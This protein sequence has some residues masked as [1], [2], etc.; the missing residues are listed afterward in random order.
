MGDG[1]TSA[2]NA[3]ASLGATIVNT[4]TWFVEL[5]HVHSS[6]LLL[7]MLAGLALAAGF[8]YLIG[9]IGWA[10]R[11]LGFVV[12]GGIRAGFRLWERLLAWASWPLF[13]AIVLGFLVGGGVVGGALPSVRVVCGLAPLLM[14]AIACLAYMF[15]DLERYE[16]E[17][18]HMAVHNPLKGQVLAIHLARYGQQVRAPLLIAATVAMIGGFALLNQGLYVTIGRGWYHVADE[19]REPI[20]VD[21][22]AYAITKLLGLVDVLD[23]AESHRLLR[24][25]NVRQAAWPASI[26]LAGFKAFFSLVLLQQIFASL[27]QGKLLAETITD[28]WSPHEPIHDRARNALAQYGVR[29]I[30]PLLVSLRSVPSLTKEQRDQLPLILA[31]IGPSTIPALVRHLHDPHEHVR[32]IAAAALGQ[33]HALDTVPLLAALGQDPSAV[34]RQ[35]VVEALGI[36]GGAATEL[37]PKKRRLGRGHGLRGRRIGWLFRWR[38]RGA[39]APLLNLVELAVATLEPA[40][41][42]DSAAVRTQAALALGRIGPPAAAVAPGLID[43]LEDADETVRCQAAEALGQVGGDE[44][45]TVAALVQLLQDASAPVKESAARAL[46]ALRKAAAP[47]VAALVPLLQDREESVR[48]AA[49]E[50]IA[51]VGPLNEAATDTLVEGL[52]SPDNVVRAQTAEALGTI[53]A[54]AEEAAPALVE[55]MADGNDRVRAKAVEALGKIGESAAAAAVPGLVRALRDQDNWVSALAAEAL[56]QMGES[57]DATV[58]ALVRSLGHL[59]PRVRG[60]SAEALGKMGEAAVAARSALET[61]AGD[62]D[63]GVR[64][65]A[66]RAL[67]TIGCPTPTSTQAIM[68]GL[69]DDD[70]LARAA[71]VESLGH[72]AEPSVAVLIGL[73]PLLEDANDQVKV[74][75]TKVLPRLA[76]ASPAVVDGLC[77]RLVEDDSAWVQVH[78]ALALGRLGRAAAAAGGPLLRAAQTGDVSVREQAMRAIALIQPPETAEAFAAGLKDACSDIRVVAS[79]GWMKAAAIP[80]EAIPTLVEALRDPETQVRANAAHALGRLD[81]LPAAAVTLL[82]ECA[83]DPYDGLRMNAA[84]ALKLA[85]A[86]AVVEVMQHLLTDPNPRV[87][88]I[89]A[90]TL[91]SAEPDNAQACAVVVEA[92]G[93]PVLRVRTASLKLV[94]SLGPGGSGFLDALKDREGMEGEAELRDVVTCLIERLENQAGLEL[95]AVADQGRMSP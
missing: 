47:A 91:L 61:A 54:A 21:F 28:F 26:L 75:V 52:D 17:R 18:G 33:L 87:R 70:P 2:P 51:Q 23:L 12:R 49:A 82:I 41:A 86:S 32:A 6:S 74:E 50:A 36:L 79:A 76:G 10:L 44:R 11:G 63:G 46:G 24:A 53:G 72:W 95:Q 60:N 37:S 5:E 4:S 13:L 69:A 1:G 88:L 42:D 78:A 65:Q 45:A 9:L 59:N 20:F 3:L 90:G 66:V 7:A 68:A 29:A 43:L 38:K 58:I 94:E 80:E 16:V 56:G 81:A 39:P 57:G 77:R 67:G 48:T 89:A 62:E 85:P 84:V 73:A 40:L 8:L 22:L 14:G 55:A 15:I 19:K 71:A 30:R 27:R 92:L 64:S 35:S 93:D 31:T 83:A 25:A 34:V